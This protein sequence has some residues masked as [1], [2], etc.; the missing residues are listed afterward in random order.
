MD[1][2]QARALLERQLT[3]RQRAAE[4]ADE[5]PPGIRFGQVLRLF[6]TARA[7]RRYVYPALTEMQAEYYEALNA[8]GRRAAR[9]VALRGHLLVVP[10]F[11]YGA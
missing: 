9:R 10:H 4:P 2:R 11:L 5:R 7:F 1:N 3:G 8:G 6:M